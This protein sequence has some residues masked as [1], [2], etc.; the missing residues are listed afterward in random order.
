VS[1][2]LEFD[3]YLNTLIRSFD[4]RHMHGTMLPSPIPLDEIYAKLG[5]D[6]RPD[7]D[8][9]LPVRVSRGFHPTNRA[10]DRARAKK[11]HDVRSYHEALNTH[12]T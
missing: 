8:G 12:W 5:P 7:P 4:P 11:Y 3:L 9:D 1:T 2:S 10:K 6:G